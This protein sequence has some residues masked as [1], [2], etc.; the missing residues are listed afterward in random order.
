MPHAEG[1]TALVIWLLYLASAACPSRSE[2]ILWV[3]NTTGGEWHEQSNWIPPR[4]PGEGDS[5]VISTDEGNA[6]VILSSN[7]TVSGLTVMGG[8]ITLTRPSSSL[9]I[10]SSFNFTAGGNSLETE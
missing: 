7:A 3:Q 6:T 10:T 8:T 2:V 1:W 5:A 4:V 9:V